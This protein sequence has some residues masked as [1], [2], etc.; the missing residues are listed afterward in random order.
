MHMFD[1]ISHGIDCICAL[2]KNPIEEFYDIKKFVMDHLKNEKSS[3][4]YQLTKILSKNIY[5][6]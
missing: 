6:T 4:Q 3:P 2:E 1:I 5:N